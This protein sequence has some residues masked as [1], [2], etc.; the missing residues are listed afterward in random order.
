VFDRVATCTDGH[1]TIK[2][3]WPERNKQKA[4]APTKSKGAKKKAGKRKGQKRKA[5]K[6]R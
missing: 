2:K 6:R 1:C 3:V 4:K 5:E